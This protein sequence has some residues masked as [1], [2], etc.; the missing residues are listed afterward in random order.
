MSAI[1]LRICWAYESRENTNFSFNSC[2]QRFVFII[3]KPDGATFAISLVFEPP[4]SQ[5]MTYF[6]GFWVCFWWEPAKQKTTFPVACAFIKV[7]IAWAKIFSKMPQHHK[8]SIL[9]LVVGRLLYLVLGHF[10]FVVFSFTRSVIFPANVIETRSVMSSRTGPFD[11]SERC[12]LW[13]KPLCTRGFFSR[14]LVLVALNLWRTINNC[15]YQTKYGCYLVL[16]TRVKIN[17]LWLYGQ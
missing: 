6:S 8:N 16:L 2:L 14:S 13:M 15:L 4:M 7:P 1:V 10:I 12:S 11:R 3:L 9:K 17:V 5:T